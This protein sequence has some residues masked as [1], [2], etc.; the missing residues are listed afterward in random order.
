VPR[1][2]HQEPDIQ[3]EEPEAQLPKRRVDKGE[4]MKL[5]VRRGLVTLSDAF[6]PTEPGEEDH[7]VFRDEE[8]VD[9]EFEAVA[10][11]EPEEPVIEVQQEL[12]GP[13]AD[14]LMPWTV[15]S[16]RDTWCL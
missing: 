11:G 13:D 2:R 16:S 15:S 7:L 14:I 10:P 4:E 3:N 8:D 12:P 5:Q 6:D 1:Q 9:E